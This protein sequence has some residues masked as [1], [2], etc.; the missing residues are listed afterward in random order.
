MGVE[1]Q[2]INKILS[3]G[4]LNIIKENGLTGEYFPQYRDCYDFIINH[5]NTYHNVPDILTFLKQFND[6]EISTVNESDKYLVDSLKENYLYTKFVPIIKKTHDYM[7][8]DANEAL[9]YLTASLPS[10]QPLRSGS[11]I[12]LTKEGAEQRYTVYLEK[13]KTENQ[14]ISSGLKQVDDICGG[15]EKGEEL[16]TVLARSNQGK[17]WLLSYFALQ[18]WLQNYR[19]GIYSG[20]MSATRIGYRLDTLNCHFS[21]K[22]LI[23]GYTEEQQ[24]YREYID[25][26]KQCQTPLFAVT[27]KELGSKATVPKLQNFIEKNELDCLIIDQFSLMED[28]RALKRDETRIQMAHISEDLFNMSSKYGIPI[29]AAAQA[30]RSGAK[31]GKDDD[32]GPPELEHIAESDAIGQ[33]SSKVLA[34]RQKDGALELQFRK[35]RESGLGTKLVYTWD[36]DFGK[37]T[38]VPTDENVSNV[39]GTTTNNT[40]RV[41]DDQT[42]VSFKEGIEIF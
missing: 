37:I 22:A 35:N 23:R 19:T 2:V 11:C 24:K 29:I 13:S 36:I 17:S 39:P 9:E 20:E 6:F 38:F 5:Y 16:I 7:E 21:N 27:P 28:H 42:L 8:S 14:T 1:D 30:N 34:M 3:Q 10:L 15:W 18:A 12:D 40:K 26:L 41:D 25:F 33:N 32:D 31:K 4:N